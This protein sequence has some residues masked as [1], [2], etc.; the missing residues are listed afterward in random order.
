MKQY[1]PHLPAKGKI[2]DQ[3]SR[4]QSWSTILIVIVI[5][6]L[7]GLAA[8]L[9]TTAW[10]VPPIRADYIWPTVDTSRRSSPV[11]VEPG[12][13]NTVRQRLLHVYDVATGDGLNESFLYQAHH[14]IA[15]AL[16]V[17]SDGWAA[18]S[19]SL[20]VGSGGY[21]GWRAVD[22]RGRIYEINQVVVDPRTELTYLQLKSDDI[23]PVIEFSDIE[24][25]Q[26]QDAGRPAWLVHQDMWQSVFVNDF[27]LGVTEEPL[28]IW[29]THRQRTLV[30]AL[31]GS[32]FVINAKGALVGI[33]RDDKTF[34]DARFV[35]L[36]TTLLLE[37]ERISYQ[38]IPIVGFF[39]DTIVVDDVV[40]PM[41]GFYVVRQTQGQSVVRQGD[42]VVSVDGHAPDPVDTPLQLLQS[43]QK[44]VLL[45][46]RRKQEE[47]EVSIPLSAVQ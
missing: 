39:I 1:P 4:S 20:A 31:S 30:G 11:V 46:V 29:Q 6:L 42:I 36:H 5:A 17:S 22:Y 21:Q 28:P 3:S 18:V 14:Q 7:S 13:Q 23:F 38:G 10:L 15:T 43:Q 16:I 47:F 26:Q 35:R 2:L 45:R 8:A 25:W 41:A 37:R 24:R 44:E 34:V 40:Q 12:L 19:Q 9:V 27:V 33:I 32:A